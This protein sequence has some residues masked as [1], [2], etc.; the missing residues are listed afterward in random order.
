MPYEL[1]IIPFV[2]VILAQILK[3]ATDG[4]KNNFN[5][6]NIFGKYGGMPSGHIS[7]I[8]SLGALIVIKHGVDSSFFAIWIIFATIVMR[9]ALGARRE[10][11]IHSSAIK[12]ISEKTNTNIPK[13]ITRMGH[14]PIE[15]IAGF[16]FGTGITLIIKLLIS[17][18]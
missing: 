14:T 6:I 7:F 3:L 2:T 8:A 9:D 5:I 11:G 10:I 15:V 18:I 16:L 1:I 12:K 17:Q 4:I 13:L